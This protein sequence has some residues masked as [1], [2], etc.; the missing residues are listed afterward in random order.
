MSDSETDIPSIVRMQIF[1]NLKRFSSSVTSVPSIL[2]CFLHGLDTMQQTNRTSYRLYLVTAFLFLTY[3]PAIYYTMRLRNFGILTAT[4]TCQLAHKEHHGSRNMASP[5]QQVRP[6]ANTTRWRDCSW[7]RCPRAYGISASNHSQTRYLLFI[8]GQLPRLELKSKFANVVAQNYKEKELYAVFLL[9]QGQSRSTVYHKRCPGPHDTDAW[10]NETS[11]TE[12][13]RRTFPN[14]SGVHLEKTYAQ[15]RLIRQV[16]YFVILDSSQDIMIRVAFGISHNEPNGDYILNPRF[17]NPQ[18]L[19]KSTQL[20]HQDAFRNIRSAMMLVE[21]LEDH[22]GMKMDYIFKLREDAFVLRPFILYDYKSKSVFVTPKC[23]EWGGYT[24]VSFIVGRLVASRVLRGLAED[25]YFRMDEH[26]GN[27][28]VFVKHLALH[29][30]SQIIR[31]SVCDW[32]VLPIIYVKG[33]DKNLSMQLRTRS[34]RV[35]YWKCIPRKAKN[36]DCFWLN[37][38]EIRSDARKPYV[39]DQFTNW[40]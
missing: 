33:A 10:Q 12:Y 14:A 4:W 1:L 21:Q 32:P 27:P 3:A 38:T 15:K 8:T 16:F 22:L 5:L 18:N 9:K 31:V 7:A 29:Y 39:A 17:S 28:E 25:Y 40:S 24:D 34:M 2:F 37:S 36:P 23:W 30:K 13:F 11:M 6:V 20:N 19:T 26:Y 35:L